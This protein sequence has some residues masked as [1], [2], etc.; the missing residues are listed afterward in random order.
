MSQEGVQGTGNLR[1]GGLGQAEREREG[2]GGGRE[3][4]RER[5][6]GVSVFIS[7][8][9]AV[10]VS[11]GFQGIWCSVGYHGFLDPQDKSLAASFSALSLYLPLQSPLH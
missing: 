8:S 2:S 11:V 6:P 5:A 1:T 9:L 4:E 7:A 3:R 10:S